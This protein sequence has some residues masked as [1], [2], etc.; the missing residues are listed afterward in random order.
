MPDLIYDLEALGYLVTVTPEG[1]I[2]AIHKQGHQLA[3]PS[4]QELLDLLSGQRIE[5]ISAR[6]QNG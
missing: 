5:V 2:S 1:G 3:N 4:Y 6:R